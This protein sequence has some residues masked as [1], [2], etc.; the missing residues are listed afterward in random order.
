MSDENR[1]SPGL[2]AKNDLIKTQP[3]VKLTNEER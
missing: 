1:K 2:E 3:P